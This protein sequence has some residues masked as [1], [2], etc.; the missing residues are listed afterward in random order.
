MQWILKLLCNYLLEILVKKEDNMASQ[1]SCDYC[2]NLV[3]DDELEE[4]VCDVNMDEDDYARLLNSK[5]K[6]C[7]YY[8]SNDEYKVVRHQM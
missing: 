8:Q 3:F 6:Q 2:N 7:P 1:Y 5:Y 4:Y